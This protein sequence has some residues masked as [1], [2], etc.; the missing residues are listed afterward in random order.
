MSPTGSAAVSRRKLRIELKSLR[1]SVDKTQKE[2]ADALEWSPSKIMRIERGQVGLTLTDLR[3]LLDQ[4]DVT[5]RDR[6]A[7]L[8]DLARD[9]R[10]S[11]LSS[12]YGDVY[13]QEFK[14]FLGYEE[15][16]RAIRQFE[17]KVIPGP[18]QTAEY[19]LAVL[20]NYAG[21]TDTRE[22]IERKVEARVARGEMLEQP[23]APRA[24][25]IM[26]EAALWRQIGAESAGKA[27]MERQLDH[28]L[29]KHSFDNIT[30]QIVPFSAGAYPAMQGPFVILDL[31]DEFLLYLENPEGEVIVHDNV[32]KIGFYLDRFASTEKLATS[33]DSLAAVIGAVR[34]RF[35]DLPLR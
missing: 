4:Y 32:D 11:T 17:T 30:I 21:P 27:V 28:L 22:R 18:L 7:R 8:A 31:D 24:L 25:F 14:E 12:S 23:D 34:S 1:L 16:A 3:A 35:T 15:A 9:S 6:A 10:K 26:D 29:Y 13:S 5:D 20:T 33:P 2:V 19:A